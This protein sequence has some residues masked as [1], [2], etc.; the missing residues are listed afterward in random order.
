ML[1]KTESDRLASL[2]EQQLVCEMPP[3]LCKIFDTA[4]IDPEDAAAV[5]QRGAFVA[6]A[7]GR[8]RTQAQDAA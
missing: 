2:P 3:I 5:E 7:R 6:C 4:G 8:D 1:T